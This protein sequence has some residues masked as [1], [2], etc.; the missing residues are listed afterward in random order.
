MQELI[1]FFIGIIILIPSFSQARSYKCN[2][3]D[4]ANHIES[5]Q[6]FD[7]AIPL[8]THHFV[9]KNPDGT[10]QL[11]KTTTFIGVDQVCGI[12]IDFSKM[13]KTRE[14]VNAEEYDYSFNCSNGTKGNIYFDEFGGGQ[15]SCQNID[16][17]SD[18]MVFGN[19]SKL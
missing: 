17:K 5:T 8:L 11:D 18:Q 15:A 9:I 13:C 10:V 4:D 19:C 7:S 12:K 1:A 16:G 3:N 6:N 2:E 14:R